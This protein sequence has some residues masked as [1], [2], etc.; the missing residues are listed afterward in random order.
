MSFDVRYS[1]VLHTTH[2]QLVEWH[3]D[4]EFQLYRPLF[5]SRLEAERRA[6]A[7]EWGHRESTSWSVVIEAV[8]P[9]FLP[10][11]GECAELP[12][13]NPAVYE[14][15]EEMCHALGNHFGWVAT[16]EQHVFCPNHR[17]AWEE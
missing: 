15:W 11:C 6:R 1:P 10:R 2:Y 5:R 7:L 4:H 8:E 12:D 16:S 17:P 3:C 9:V 14:T 13:D